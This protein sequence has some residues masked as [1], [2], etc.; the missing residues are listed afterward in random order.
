MKTVKTR[1]RRTQVRVEPELYQKLKKLAASRHVSMAALLRQGIRLLIK[2]EGSAEK[3]SL[4][5]IVGMGSGRP[6]NVSETHDEFLIECELSN[7]KRKRD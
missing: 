7:L 1:M 4:L 2:E 6:C 5:S 3:H